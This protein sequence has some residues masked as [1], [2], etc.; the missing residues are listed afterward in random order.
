MLEAPTACLAFVWF[1]HSWSL[2]FR[3]AS[4]S[5][6]SSTYDAISS[7][8]EVTGTTAG[9]SWASRSK[10]THSAIS[11]EH[12]TATTDS[13]LVFFYTLLHITFLKFLW[14]SEELEIKVIAHIASR[15]W[16]LGMNWM[17]M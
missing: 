12:S 9:W 15:E 4:D 3:S 13:T 17:M 11:T 5:A 14:V 16:K 10:T 7:A 6:T 1:D 8:T 2:L